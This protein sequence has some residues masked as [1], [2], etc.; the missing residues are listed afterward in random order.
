MTRSAECAHELRMDFEFNDDSADPCQELK[1]ARLK[2]YT[3]KAR[4]RALEK[5]LEEAR[6][7][8]RVLF[9]MDDTAE[10]PYYEALIKR[11][12]KFLGDETANEAD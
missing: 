7:L 2:V 9:E 6:E 12:N 4:I 3:H 1:Q 5:E 8:V 11:A 10:L